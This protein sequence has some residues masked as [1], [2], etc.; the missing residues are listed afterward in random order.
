MGLLREGSALVELAKGHN[1]DLARERV[2]D[3][4]G[5]A[6]GRTPRDLVTP[7]L[8]LD[9]DAARRNCEH[10]AQ[11]LRSMPA[12]L[13]PHIKT[14][15]NPDLARMQVE[16]GAV[17]VGTATVWEAAIMAEAGIEDIFV[18]NQ[19]VGPAKIHTL[20]DLARRVSI[21]VAVDDPGNA[22]ELSAAAVAAGVTLGAVIE[23]D[24]GMDRAGVDTAQQALELARH[25]AGLQGLVLEGLTGYEGHCSDEFDQVVRAEKQ[26]K[27]MALFVS[28][29]DLLEANGFPCRILS[30]GGTATWNLTAATPRITEI[31][32]GSYLLMDAY[33]GGPKGLIPGSGFEFALT[34][35]TTVISRPGGRL[36][37]DCGSKS[38]GEPGMSWIVGHEDIG[39]FGFHEEHGVFDEPRDSG[40]RIGDVVQLI[41]G[42]TPYTVNYYDAF[43][44]VQGGVVVDIWPIIPRGPGH[45]GLVKG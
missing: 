38:I 10:M 1:I 26:R 39:V 30:A 44:V 16:A 12:K 25:V 35:A 36:I 40:L 34:V 2:S 5:A 4:Y 32:A 31:Q 14:H 41:P 9:I 8:V 13:R 15:K 17:G 37:V 3:V 27:A 21:M 45:W 42:Y 33:H 24:T 28:V 43:H 22:A 19:V 18:I 23:V 29:A 7:A 20:C 11:Q 6:L